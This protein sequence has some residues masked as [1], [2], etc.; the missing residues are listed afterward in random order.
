VNV[1]LKN[2]DAA[3]A[4][5]WNI[6]DICFNNYPVE[7]SHGTTIVSVNFTTTINNETKNCT[8]IRI[9]LDDGITCM[10][11]Y[12]FDDTWTEVCRGNYNNPTSGNWYY[13]SARNVDF[14]ADPQLVSSAFKEWLIANATRIEET[15]E[16][17][18]GTVLFLI[19]FT[20]DETEYQALEGMTWA[21]W[22]DSSY[23]TGGFNLDGAWSNYVQSATKDY[24]IV[25]DDTNVANTATISTIAYTTRY[26]QHN[27]G[28]NN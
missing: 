2:P 3:I 28:P 15:V 24:Y 1:N 4:G 21:E 23:N 26:I 17:Y 12:Q 14:G 8:G 18:D 5:A 27:G 16:E 13:E 11:D 20:I 6:N 22:V 25:L 9:T 10:I 7:N 19:S